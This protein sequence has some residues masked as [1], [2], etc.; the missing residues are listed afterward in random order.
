MAPSS[1]GPDPEAGSDPDTDSRPETGS[2][3]ES[4]PATD[5]APSST[6][7][8]PPVSDTGDPDAFD[9]GRDWRRI[10]PGLRRAWSA[11]DVG[12][13]AVPVLLGTLLVSVP[14][15]LVVTWVT[16]ALLGVVG[17]LTPEVALGIVVFLTLTTFSSFLFSAVML[18]ERLLPWESPLAL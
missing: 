4:D 13:A 2:A 8:D 5:V 10:E 12:K 11:L 14:Y 7:E 9:E 17:V 3:P 15:V 16:D 18:V 1:S 6:F